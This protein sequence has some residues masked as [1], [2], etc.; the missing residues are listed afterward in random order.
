[1]IFGACPGADFLRNPNIS[2]QSCPVCGNS[3][4]LFPT[5]P[6][7][8]CDVC[9][10]TSCNPVHQQVYRRPEIKQQTRFIPQ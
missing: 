8:I 6:E 1:M 2:E 3:I 4:E 5:D 10:F 9:G 7:L